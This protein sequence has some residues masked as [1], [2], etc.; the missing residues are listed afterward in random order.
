[1]RARREHMIQ[2]TK[3]RARCYAH[4]Y[5]TVYGPHGVAMNWTLDAA[6]ASYYRCV[7]HV[8]TE[9]RP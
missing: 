3:P 7:L 4:G 9:R 1:M 8:M 2:T 5:W 6:L